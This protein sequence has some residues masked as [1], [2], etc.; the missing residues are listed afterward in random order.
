MNQ[1]EIIELFQNSDSP[2]QRRHAAELLASA[3]DFD[4][5]SAEVLVN[6][7]KDKDIGVRDLVFRILQSRD[8][9]HLKLINQFVV[10][11]IADE[12]IEIR[13]LCAEI[14]K[15]T[16]VY[17]PEVF[18]QYLHH[19]DIHIR[20][21]AVDICSAVESDLILFEL[22]CLLAKEESTNVRASLIEALGNFK[23]TEAE[24]L[25]INQFNQEIDLKPVVIDALAKFGTSK[26]EEFIISILESDTDE[27][28]K[29]ACLDALSS[30][31]SNEMLLD[32]LLT[33]MYH[34]PK[35][36][37]S[38]VL[39]AIVLI[40][41]RINKTIEYDEKFQE[42]AKAAL[43]EED[44]MIIYS[45]LRVLG[46]NI[47]DTEIPILASV[48]LRE[49]TLIMHT[50]LE[51]L[52]TMKREDFLTILLKEIINQTYNQGSI[53]NLISL[54]PEAILKY[55]AP[56]SVRL[57]QKVLFDLLIE[58]LIDPSVNN[59]ESIQSLDCSNFKILTELNSDTIPD[60]IREF[61][62]YL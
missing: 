28:I 16:G 58:E 6:G 27:F 17:S 25:L 54:L 2:D 48:I 1:K 24:T 15:L 8:I 49:S 5:L 39:M 10:H 36:I 52:V 42:I 26:S 35:P 18:L 57:F 3:P 11:L 40:S 56:H 23:D 55:N 12:N 62:Q 51:I 61:T 45:G 38:M 50:V 44:E 32:K 4:A 41:E 59:L 19:S 33:N 53:Q 47:S 46:T 14:L 22:K 31:S 30:F 7:L 21:F 29:I 43:S 37:R 20:Q 34:F 13:N 9:E 60:E